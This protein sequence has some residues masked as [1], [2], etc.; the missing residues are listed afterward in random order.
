MLL[1]PSFQ[2]DYEKLS[3]EIV[4]Y[5]KCARSNIPYIEEELDGLEYD[6]DLPDPKTLPKQLSREPY[7]H[8]EY[9][10]D[11][12]R[13]P[14]DENINPQDYIAHLEQEI[15]KLTEQNVVTQE[16]AEKPKA[17]AK[18]KGKE[19]PS[20]EENEQKEGLTQEE[21]AQLKAIAMKIPDIEY[22]A[23]D[24]YLEPTGGTESAS[25]VVK[26]SQEKQQTSRAAT[27]P[28]D[29]SRKSSNAIRQSMNM[30]SREFSKPPSIANLIPDSEI[31]T[32]APSRSLSEKSVQSSS[33]SLMNVSGTNSST[34]GSLVSVWEPQDS[35]GSEKSTPV[36]QRLNLRNNE[37][38][39]SSLYTAREENKQATETKLED[40][41]RLRTKECAE[42]A[43]RSFQAAVERAK[44]DL[45]SS[46]KHLAK[47]KEAVRRL[48]TAPN[49]K[50]LKL[51]A[52]RA[53]QTNNTSLGSEKSAPKN[54][55]ALPNT[56]P[57]Q[58]EATNP[59]TNPKLGGAMKGLQ[60][61]KSQVGFE[62]QKPLP[63]IMPSQLHFQP[64]KPT[65]E[66]AQSKAKAMEWESYRKK[67]DRSEMEYAL[68]ND[69]ERGLL[70]RMMLSSKE[71]PRSNKKAEDLNPVKDKGKTRS[72]KNKSQNKM[73]NKNDNWV[74]LRDSHQARGS[75]RNYD[76]FLSA[77]G[78]AMKITDPNVKDNIIT[79]S[80]CVNR[81][82]ASREVKQNPGVRRIGF[83]TPDH[84]MKYLISVRS[85][86]QDDTSLVS[87]RPIEIGQERPKER[88]SKVVGQNTQSIYAS[89][90]RVP[91]PLQQF[92]DA[93]NNGPVSDR[94]MLHQS[95]SRNS[96]AESRG[97]KSKMK[98]YHRS[99]RANYDR[100]R[101]AA[102]DTMLSPRGAASADA[103]GNRMSMAAA[104][105]PETN[106]GLMPA[107]T[108]RTSKW[109]AS[110]DVHGV[111]G[112]PETTEP[113]SR[114][115]LNAEEEFESEHD[116]EDSIDISM[117]ISE[118]M[119]PSYLGSCNCQE[120]ECQYSYLAHLMPTGNYLTALH[121]CPPILGR[122]RRDYRFL[123]KKPNRTGQLD[124]TGRVKL[125]ERP[126]VLD[127]IQI[128]EDLLELMDDVMIRKEILC[129]S[130]GFTYTTITFTKL[131]PKARVV[132]KVSPRHI[133]KKSGF[134]E[135][136]LSGRR[137][138]KGRN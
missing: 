115:R 53:A 95:Q 126:P 97:G 42:T 138:S 18:G 130:R 32:I 44:G 59:Q 1:V 82:G 7:S 9:R 89:Q 104:E 22:I 8:K 13:C 27:G 65:Q 91:K 73:Y 113:S 41:K 133:L 6:E 15:L 28:K 94:P 100:N 83:T 128:G 14:S 124:S 33:H 39:V 35:Q 108:H 78:T 69:L 25:D 45:Y 57:S 71:A 23:E 110:A 109:M 60:L 56:A 54:K 120:C 99:Q 134:S 79:G 123:Q 117:S 98:I 114:G 26:K 37:L 67:E 127:V 47:K 66:K 77:Y 121:G 51:A 12:V 19:G 38:Y 84:L 132:G 70:H 92:V 88:D 122:L 85:A 68:K 34:I 50:H 5:D 17:P 2:F 119:E 135:S 102:S 63:P 24:P 43:Q 107:E 36:W 30:G 105:A 40:R 3:I 46:F 81:S 75:F 131:D 103:P 111:H 112:I 136:L 86:L 72:E 55:S 58:V 118:F 49:V 62:S 106:N 29:E 90:R 4:F 96:P 10:L 76:L 64:K 80:F 125:L 87:W 129:S 116:A 93:N 31:P 21:Q 52:A 16:E 61:P 74:R 48:S 101:S 11:K 20:R 137:Y